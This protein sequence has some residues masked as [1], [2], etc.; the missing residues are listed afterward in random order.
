MRI[1][2]AKRAV[3][4]RMPAADLGCLCFLPEV[5]QLMARFPQQVKV[6]LVSPPSFVAFGRQV[7]PFVL[8]T[9]DNAPVLHKLRRS[10]R[11]FL[12]R[13]GMARRAGP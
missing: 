3:L 2:P 11:A 4:V 7:V 5:R 9:T 6:N 1:M 10:L 8:A 12:K 13:E